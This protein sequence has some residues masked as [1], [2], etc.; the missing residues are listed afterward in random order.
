VLGVVVGTAVG[1]SRGVEVWTRPELEFMRA[2]P[3]V[4]VFPPMLLILGTGDTMKVAAIALS[5]MWPIVLATTD[6][7]R[8][9]EPARRDM[10]RVFGLPLSA[11]LRH[12]V[13]PTAVPHIWSGVRAA[14]PIALVVLIAAEYYASKNG[15][16]YFISETSTSF[17]L[18]DMWSAVLLLGVIG[19]AVNGIVALIG[20]LLD[21]R[22]GEHAPR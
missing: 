13:L 15:I 4:L 10:A 3:P 18:T 22:F 1:L 17:R 9:V 14:T 16:G 8:S 5:A 7:V 11:Q 21:R 19:V 12:V 20:R 2:L 6:G